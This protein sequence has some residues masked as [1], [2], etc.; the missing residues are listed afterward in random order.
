MRSWQEAT[1][2]VQVLKAGALPA[3]V[4]VRE[5]REVGQ[6]LGEQSVID[7]RNAILFGSLWSSSL[8]SF[9]TRPAALWRTS[10]S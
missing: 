4:E 10:H 5:K 3:P 6:T 9:T 1:D 2:L 8:C 7:G